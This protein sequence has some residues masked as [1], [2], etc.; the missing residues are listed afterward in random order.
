L[1]RMRIATARPIAEPIRIDV[2]KIARATDPS[3]L[4]I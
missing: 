2:E 4:T 3:L 1:V